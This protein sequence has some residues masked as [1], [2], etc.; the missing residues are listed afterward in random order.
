MLAE[1]KIE[2]ALVEDSPS[3]PGKAVAD[4]NPLGKIPVLVM[5]DGTRLFD[6]RV[7]VEYLDTVSPVIRLIPEPS[8]DRIAV[9]RWEAL[10]DGLRDPA[11]AIAVEKKRPLRR[12][13]RKWI[14]RQLQ[15]VVAVVHAFAAELGDASWCSGETYTLAGALVPKAYRDGGRSLDDWLAAFGIECTIRHNAVS[16]ALGT[17]ELLLRLRAIA[18]KQGIRGFEALVKAARAQKWLGNAD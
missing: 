1:Q 2:Y 5:D 11:A 18:A 17:A 8:R 10:A 3:A 6:S 7:F 12:Q 16:D 15:K 4:F 14:E 9:K 13:S